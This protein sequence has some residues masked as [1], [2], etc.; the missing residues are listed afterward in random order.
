[1]AGYGKPFARTAT[2]CSASSVKA[3]FSSAVVSPGIRRPANVSGQRS[4]AVS[5]RV[6]SAP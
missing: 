3:M 6:Q 5:S 1:M 4:R 2:F